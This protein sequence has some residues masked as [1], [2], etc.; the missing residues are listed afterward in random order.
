MK[1]RSRSSRTA[2]TRSLATLLVVISVLQLRVA[3]S[4]P[5]D[6]F[7]SPAPALSAEPVKAAD[8]KAGDLTVSSQ[9]GAISWGY[10]VAV[11]P[12]RSG[13]SH[14]ISLS[15]SSQSPA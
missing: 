8:I 15:Y 6:T 2:F 5:A 12:G 14:G 4:A 13:M 1:I 3:R 7:A 9:T 10:P 11:P